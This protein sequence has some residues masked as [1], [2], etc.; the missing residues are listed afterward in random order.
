[1]GSHIAAP[2]GDPNVDDIYM[3]F[4]CGE[5]SLEAHHQPGLRIPSKTERVDAENR[6][7]SAHMFWRLIPAASNP[8]IGESNE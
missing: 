6:M 7:Q 8:A 4:S 5:I 1:M 2:N 3:C